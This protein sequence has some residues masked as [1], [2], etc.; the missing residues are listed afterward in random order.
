[1]RVLFWSDTF[2]PQIGGVEVLAAKL[3]PALQARGF[4]FAVVAPKSH[5]DLPDQETFRGVPVRRFLFFNNLNLDAVEHIAETRD[6]LIEFKRSF[7]PKL[8]HLNH[9]GVS[10]FFHLITSKV[11]ASPTLLTLHGEWPDRASS[12]VGR[13][14]RSAEWVAGCSAAILNKARTLAPEI[15]PARQ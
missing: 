13:T 10:H 15:L 5:P 4:E 3:L 6:K 7:A 14:L 2:W 1:M 9:A 12:I 8:I 11:H